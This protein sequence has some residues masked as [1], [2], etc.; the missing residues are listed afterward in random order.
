[1]VFFFLE[2][3]KGAVQVQLARAAADAEGAAAQQERR[4]QRRLAGRLLHPQVVR[5]QALD[6]LP[7]GRL[8]LLRQAQLRGALEPIARLHDLQH[9]ARHAS[10]YC[11]PSVCLLFVSS[12]A[13]N[14][15][16]EQCRQSALS[17]MATFSR[18]L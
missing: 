3:K 7:G 16:H 5:Q 14:E 11:R 13:R 15:K 10:R 6:R 9:V 1:M 18:F 8:A 2:K 12:V 4:V 17:L